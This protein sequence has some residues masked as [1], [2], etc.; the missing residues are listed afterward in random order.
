MR[1]EVGTARLIGRDTEFDH[2]QRAFAAVAPA[3]GHAVLIRGE[4]G[5]GKSRLLAET[6]EAGAERFQ[7]VT[8]TASELETDLPFAPLVRALGLRPRSSDPYAAELGRLLEEPDGR[9]PDVRRLRS[10][11]GIADLVE[12][13]SLDRPVLLA[14]EDVHWADDATLQTLDRLARRLQHVG[15]L[16]TMTARPHPRSVAFEILERT[17]VDVG[18]TIVELDRLSDDAVIELA[19]GFL[20]GPPGPLLESAL[21]QAA[22]NPLYVTELLTAARS[23]LV[24]EDS[25]PEL[26]TAGV[27]ESVRLTILR[28]LSSLPEAT[29]DVLR[30]AS[31]LGTRFDLTELAL[32]LDRPE[33][34]VVRDLSPAFSSQVIS[35]AGERVEFRH[36]LVRGAIYEDQPLAVR[37]LMHRRVVQ[38]LR[39]AGLPMVDLV[40]HLLR[41]TWAGMPE[42]ADWLAEAGRTMRGRSL[43]LAA[44]LL[45]RAVDEA[46]D[47]APAEVRLD[48]AEVLVA[49]GRT[50]D[51]LAALQPI[52]ATPVDDLSEE[53]RDRLVPLAAAFME[54]GDE[55]VRRVPSLDALEEAGLSV[56]GRAQAMAMR[57]WKRWAR[58]DRED[59]GTLANEAIVL[60]EQADDHEGASAL[61]LLLA[62]LAEG[63]RWDGR[64]AIHA[65]AGLDHARCVPSRPELALTA[66]GTLAL[67]LGNDA[68]TRP[69]A[70]RIV[71]EGLALA[72][73]TGLDLHQAA[74]EAVGALNLQRAGEWQE[75][76]IRYEAALTA[77]PDGAT[78]AVGVAASALF[79]ARAARLLVHCDELD[80]ASQV[81]R[82]AQDLRG[83]AEELEQRNDELVNVDLAHA[84]LCV[85]LG[86]QEGALAAVADVVSFIDDRAM[87]IYHAGM[88]PSIAAIGRDVGRPEEVQAAVERAEM[89]LT[90]NDVDDPVLT[91][92]VRWGRARLDDD[93]GI[94]DGL[95]AWAD[96]P[97]P[98]WEWRPQIREDAAAV[99]AASGETDRAVQRLE[100]AL[101]LWDEAGAARDVGRVRRALRELGVHR[102]RGLAADRPDTGWES[103]TDAEWKVVE[104]VGQGLIY[105]EIG[106]RLFISRRTVETHV[107]HVFRKL[108][109][110]SRRELADLLDT[111]ENAARVAGSR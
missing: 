36:D 94:V 54:G 79:H 91:A 20:G 38:R 39:S 5:I 40:P 21:R 52:L 73:R 65:R 19:T 107:Q 37:A 87:P 75:A 77:L 69:E 92:L 31:V 45:R 102:G 76:A 70:E 50:Q 58:G 93:A 1:T 59:A 86:D 48:L 17:L 16:L 18:A 12:R 108:D 44:E 46:G 30:I 66:T 8:E 105:R 7:I 96:G 9:D 43:P 34:D 51:A 72:V 47:R 71:A 60:A 15:V 104:L 67:I 84:E 6:L 4:A 28:N 3:T 80:R 111:N 100:E 26:P 35:E 106:E 74:L 97:R 27:P 98:L 81:L 14:V 103:L 62:R 78:P 25:P 32:V 53:I 10:I 13:R 41:G 83:R 68:A 101:T 99:L 49:A 110:S 88:L 24:A 57:A 82:T 29:I 2:V 63:T 42:A 22:G 55:T 95:V 56:R 85:A 64:A 61:E 33:V 90:R 109:I 23:Q 89:W 11:E